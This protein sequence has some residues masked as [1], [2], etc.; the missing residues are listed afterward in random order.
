MNSM[1]M[2]DMINEYVRAYNSFDIEGM[3]A[4]LHEKIEFRNISSGSIDVETKGIEEFR[5]I[6]EQSK[7]LFSYRCQTI[8][9]YSFEDDKTQVAIDY[10][11]ILAKD[12]PNGMKAGEKI[13]LKGKSV[14]AFRDDKVAVIED[15]S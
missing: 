11:G 1:K 13:H 2:K 3:I 8:I 5:E 6:A 9:G 7:S 14:F 4:L 10:E 12:L 15:H